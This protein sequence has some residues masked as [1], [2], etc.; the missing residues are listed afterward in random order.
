MQTVA[1]QALAERSRLAQLRYDNGSAA[2]LEVLDA[3]RNLLDAEQQLVQVRRALLS[4]QVALY[5]AL[6][7]GPGQRSGGAESG[8]ST[9]SQRASDIP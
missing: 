6:G 7:G 5:G 4:S 2:Y 8:L 1:R 9:H 3:Q